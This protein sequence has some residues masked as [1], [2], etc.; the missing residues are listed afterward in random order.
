MK[1]RCAETSGDEGGPTS[2]LIVGHIEAG[3]ASVLVG[4]CVRL[5]GAACRGYA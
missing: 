5:Q 2:D 1:T 4:D 3:A